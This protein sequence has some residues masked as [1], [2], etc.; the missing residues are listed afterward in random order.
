[1]AVVES[2]TTAWK[3]DVAPVINTQTD[4]V[5]PPPHSKHVA[6]QTNQHSNRH[7]GKNSYKVMRNDNLWTVIT[8]YYGPNQVQQA[9]I[10]IQRQNPRVLSL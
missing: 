1:M 7:S 10:A 2:P 4:S 6:T 8:E 3:V 5:Q 9:M